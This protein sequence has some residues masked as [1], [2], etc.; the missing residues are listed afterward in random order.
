MLNKDS[1]DSN[2]TA[3]STTQGTQTIINSR[4]SNEVAQVEQIVHKERDR[5]GRIPL[6][7][8]LVG[9]FGLVTTFYGF[10]KILDRSSF[11]DQPYLMIVIGVSLLLATG[12]AANKL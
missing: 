2:P 6:L 10:E 7:L 4:L 8:P 12:A 5:L 3:K 9:T 11:I 1:L